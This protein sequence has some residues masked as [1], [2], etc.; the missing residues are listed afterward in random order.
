MTLQELPILL[1]LELLKLVFV[2]GLPI[3]FFGVNNGRHLLV[4][5]AYLYIDPIKL[6]L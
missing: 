2:S 3:Y 6:K 1:L 4:F 5:H